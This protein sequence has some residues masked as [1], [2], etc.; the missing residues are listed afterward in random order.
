MD[1]VQLYAKEFSKMT[2]ERRAM[3][4]DFTVQTLLIPDLWESIDPM[5]NYKLVK[6]IEEPFFERLNGNIVEVLEDRFVHK[7][8]VL[9][10]G[11]FFINQDGEME[12]EEIHVPSNSVV[13]RTTVNINLRNRIEVDGNKVEIPIPDTFKYVD[14][15]DVEEEETRYYTYFIPKENLQEKELKALVATTGYRSKRFAGYKV[16]LQ[17]GFAL[18]LYIIPFRRQ[19]ID[20]FRVLKISTDENETFRNEL[21]YLFEFWEDNS[22]MF[23]RDLTQLPY[24]YKGKTNLAIERITPSLDATTEP[25]SPDEGPHS[26]L[27]GTTN[28]IGSTQ[29]HSSNSLDNLYLD[30]ERQDNSVGIVEDDFDF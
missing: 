10:T 3:T 23:N 20:T 16:I 7:R 1:I 8:L 13:I 14:Y 4:D 9:P 11:E 21:E 27:S 12:T 22:I 15:E 19:K 25:T 5:K 6:G 28:S 29:S 26:S 2:E 18:N 17:N 24:V 30:F